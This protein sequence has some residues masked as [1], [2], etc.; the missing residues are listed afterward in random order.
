MKKYV[1]FVNMLNKY[2][3]ILDLKSDCLKEIKDY[4]NSNIINIT[5]SNINNASSFELKDNALYS[6]YHYPNSNSNKTEVRFMTYNAKESFNI[7]WSSLG[8]DCVNIE[9]VQNETPLEVF[10]T[11]VI[12][13]KNLY[14]VPELSLF[15]APDTKLILNFLFAIQYILDQQ[16]FNNL[17]EAKGF[18]KD[19]LCKSL[20]ETDNEIEIFKIKFNNQASKCNKNYLSTLIG[21]DNDYYFDFLT[22]HRADR[23]EIFYCLQLLSVD[24]AKNK[25]IINAIEHYN[26]VFYYNSKANKLIGKLLSYAEIYNE[27]ISRKYSQDIS[28]ENYQKDFDNNKVEDF[29]YNVIL[30]IKSKTFFKS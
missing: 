25:K 2:S 4:A 17:D 22:R 5:N 20:I 6:Y 9:I 10:K 15:N 13:Y 28:L 11:K 21:I 30:P 18:L 14:N 23:N 26:H 24:A 19:W 12:N 16:T 8:N 3:D 1:S 7:V 27:E 29:K